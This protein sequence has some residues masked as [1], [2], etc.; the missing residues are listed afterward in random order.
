MK[1]INWGQM[2]LFIILCELVGSIGAIF[3]NPNIPTW[4]VGL[5]KA[6]LNPPNWVFGPAW[7]LLFLL[8][9]VSSYLVFKEGWKKKEV[10]DAFLIF[11]VQFFFNIM[12]SLVFFGGRSPLY[13][14]FVIAVLWLTII[15]NIVAFW[16]VNKTAGKL[17]IPYLLWVSFASYLNLMVY[18]LN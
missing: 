11:G 3:T 13:G 6:S 16:R 17:L 2:L 15:L 14:L 9:G 12:W 4:Y 7:S 5:N 8:M 18:L 1:K 10:K